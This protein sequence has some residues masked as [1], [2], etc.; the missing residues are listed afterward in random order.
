MW[1][2]SLH[3]CKITPDVKYLIISF[4]AHFWA[5]VF[6]LNCVAWLFIFFKKDYLICSACFLYPKS[7]SVP[8][9]TAQFFIFWKR[10]LFNCYASFLSPKPNSTAWEKASSWNIYSNVEIFLFIWH[11]HRV[12]PTKPYNRIWWLC[13]GLRTRDHFILPY[14]DEQEGVLHRLFIIWPMPLH[15]FSSCK[16]L[17]VVWWPQILLPPRWTKWDFQFGM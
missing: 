13:V 1:L 6:V 7:N 11:M 12:K 15:P 5:S 9:H 16:W 4:R 2:T 14:R 10:K 17:L 8:N 3:L